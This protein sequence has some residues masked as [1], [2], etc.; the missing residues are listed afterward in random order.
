MTLDSLERARF[1]DQQIQQIKDRLSITDIIG[2]K[3]S[4]RKMGDEATG[5][6]PFH[7]EKTPSFT[8]NETKQFYHCFGC[9]AHGDIFSFVMHTDN[10]SFAEALRHLGEQAGITPAEIYDPQTIKEIND[11]DDI[12][13]LAS[14][15]FQEML[16]HPANKIA[17]DYLQSRNI[18]QESIKKF[19]LGFAP[20]N[21]AALDSFL[22]KKG[23]TPQA[24]ESAKIISNQY[25]TPYC[26]FAGRI[27]FPIIN[28]QNNIV[29]FG[30]RA[31]T[32]KGPK[33][34]NSPETPIF[35]KRYALYGEHLV[36]PQEKQ[37]IITEGYFD[38][39]SL[40]QAGFSNVLAPMGTGL[41]SEQAE[42][43][44][45]KCD[46]SLI[47]FDG[48][49]AGNRAAF[50]ALTNAMIPLMKPGF[51]C[52]VVSLP[53]KEDPDGMVQHNGADAL[54]SL[55]EKATPS[56]KFIWKHITQEANAADLSELSLIMSQTRAI[57]NSIKDIDV[58]SAYRTF[59][60]K[61]A[62]RLTYK[63][64]R[65]AHTRSSSFSKILFKEQ[66]IISILFAFPETLNQAE[67]EENIGQI[68]F[69]NP[70]LG[71]I[72]DIIIEH[73][74]RS[75]PMTE[76]EMQKVRASLSE[77]HLSIVQNMEHD[78]K[79]SGTA[80]DLSTATQVLSYLMTEGPGTETIEQEIQETIKKWKSSTNLSREDEEAY[81]NKIT[82]LRS[83][84]KWLNNMRHNIMDSLQ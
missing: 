61:Q 20:Q 7:N 12:N 64:E 84:F 2:R 18:S 37:T 5:L 41:T 39:I 51:T 36:S 63:T 30:G 62:N 81:I 74:S 10:L 56:E 69:H 40:A 68:T 70:A 43:I 54:H 34:L 82:G 31:L 53:N 67:M 49:E 48:D 8:V 75:A 44:W 83:Y 60:F 52:K 57:T 79:L 47:M 33:Y 16:T 78:S 35:K 42:I 11:I 80:K 4:L 9:Q 25:G 58:K 72:R 23:S 27:I 38:V 55:I 66:M 73:L 21:S 77:E 59:F 32:C 28:K 50:K 45:R 3:V 24:I 17:M 1:S 6:C 76:E 46:K 26:R 14:A 65:E 71:E 13:N 19:K 15:W 29:G 22:R